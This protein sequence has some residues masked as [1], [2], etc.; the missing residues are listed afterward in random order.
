MSNIARKS[1]VLSVIVATV[2][3]L[4]LQGGLTHAQAKTTIVWFVGMGTGTNDQQIA[5]EKKVVSEFN[6]SQSAI[7][8]QI[9]IAPTFE[10]A[11]DT[12]TTLI[13][14]GNPPD[15]VGPVG[16]GGSNSFADPWLD[17][18]DL[19]AKNKFDTSVFDPS[20]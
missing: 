10:T 5:T 11:V 16:V 1:I 8:L 19:I 13:A 7:D 15:I 18:K 2:F 20:V 3:A 9:Q 12:I 14:S 17:L 6:A 4:A